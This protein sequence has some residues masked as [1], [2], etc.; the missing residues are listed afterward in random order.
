M[1]EIGDLSPHLQVRL[2]RVLRERTYEPLGSDKPVHADIRIVA[3][4]TRIWMPW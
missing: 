4:T 2:L 3:A 1:D